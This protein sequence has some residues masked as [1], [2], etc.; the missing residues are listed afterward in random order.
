M[1]IDAKVHSIREL[2]DFYFVVPDY[3]REYVWEA[4]DQ[5]EQFL[6]DIEAEY[7]PNLKEP[8]AYFI[9]S[10]IIVNRDGK[11]DVIDGQQRLTTIVIA[12][13]AFRDLLTEAELDEKQKQYLQTIREWLSHFD[14]KTDDTQV[15][16]ELQYE[17][18]RDFL[19]Q[20]I[21]GHDYEGGETASIRRMVEA[22]ARIRGHFAEV[23]ESNVEELIKYARYFLTAIELVVIKSENLSSALKIFETINQRGVG[24]NAMDL[25]KNLLFSEARETDFTAIK[26]T[27][28]KLVKNLEDCRDGEKPLRF[29]KYFLVGRYHRGILRED[30]IYKWI[31][32]AEGKSALSYQ[33]EPLKLAKELERLAQRYSKL[34]N[35]TENF[36]DHSPF[37]HVS[38]IGFVNKYGSRQHL[39]LLLALPQGCDDAIIDHLAEQIESF[40][41]YSNALGIQGRTNEQL[42]ARWALELR[43]AHSNQAIDTVVCRTMIPYLR[44]KISDFKA[45]FPAL[46]HTTF[47]PLYRQRFILGRLE[48]TLRKKAGLSLQGNEFIQSLQ[49]EHILPQ[50]P[51]DKLVPEEFEDYE[52]YQ[53]TVAKLG[54]VTL[55][56]SMINQA[57]N[58][59][60]ELSSD[61]FK[62]KQ[63]EYVKS[64]LV[65]TN[66]LDPNYQI[67]KNTGL[68]R[69]RE[70]ISYSFESWDRKNIENRQHVLMNLSFET[71]KLCGQR[72]DDREHDQLET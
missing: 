2:K 62:K 33:A 60:N 40:L 68:N 31:I 3:Q 48:N 24:L 8:P 21:Q 42:F 46:V 63:A 10:I 39:V 57:V 38:N 19:S 5:V 4:D 36:S 43:E 52:D 20:L 22:Y 72:L 58:N 69:M 49:I 54:N 45:K 6:S 30:E 56:E 35:A 55:L 11:Y 15:R 70:S 32:S 71:W 51:R 16:L 29:L 65:M 44:E 47:N 13:C 14:I 41:F 67:G 26:E 53:S 25:V 27:W 64:D 59:L 28:R 23:R 37:P 66:M 18:S 9:G 7:D 12:L 1:H 17:E 34:V 50:T 61:W